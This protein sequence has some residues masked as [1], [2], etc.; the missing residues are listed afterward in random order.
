MRAREVMNRDRGER[1]ERGE[2]GEGGGREEE[3]SRRRE[4]RG[5]GNPHTSVK[6]SLCRESRLALSLL[7][8]RRGGK[9][10]CGRSIG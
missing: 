6:N 3:S 5:R 7:S 2:E 1:G 9:M 8:L 4:K 10:R